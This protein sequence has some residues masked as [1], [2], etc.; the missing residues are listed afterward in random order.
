MAGRL[1]A[2][3]ARPRQARPAEFRVHCGPG[4][5]RRI[6]A[7]PFTLRNVKQDLQDVGSNF[8]G[9]PDLEFRLATGALELE[10]SGLSYQR[11]PPRLSLSV[12][13]HAQE[14]GGGVRGGPRERA[15]EA[16]RRDR[17]PQGVGRGAR[18]AGYV[19][20]LR[21]RAEG[22]EIL[23]IGAP[24]LG[25][26][27]REDV[28]GQRDW[29]TDSVP[30]PPETE[31]TPRSATRY[32]WIRPDSAGF[33]LGPALDVDLA[34]GSGGAA[35]EPPPTKSRDRRRLDQRVRDR[36]GRVDPGRRASPSRGAAPPEGFGTPDA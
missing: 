17:R 36:P 29:W 6:A 7:V 21:G 3:R 1:W 14:A 9:A 28:E 34:R 31:K 18:P 16:R 10:E 25:D 22:L 4:M 30:V 5:H 8:D 35:A 13:P 12:W 24:N 20:R 15:D 2:P 26:A 32:S 27:P 11:V 33:G 19:A 23:V